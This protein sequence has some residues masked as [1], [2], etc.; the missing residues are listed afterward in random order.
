MHPEESRNSVAMDMKDEKFIADNLAFIDTKFK[1]MA[2]DL[3]RNGQQINEQKI[4]QGIIEGLQTKQITPNQIG[5]A[6]IPIVGKTKREEVK[7]V[8]ETRE[9]TNEIEGEEVGD[10]N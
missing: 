9:N 7:K 10:D 6:T 4:M 3:K 8:E 5:Q 2:M 1:E